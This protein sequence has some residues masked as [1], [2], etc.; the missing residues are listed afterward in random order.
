MEFFATYIYSI[1]RFISQDWPGDKSLT[2]FNKYG[3]IFLL[4]KVRT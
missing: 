1:A 3:M 4:K 2:L